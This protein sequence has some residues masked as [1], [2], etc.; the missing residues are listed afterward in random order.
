MWLAEAICPLSAGFS[1]PAR[2]SVSERDV[3]AT[4]GCAV[5]ERKALI[6]LRNV[7]VAFAAGDGRPMMLAALSPARRA[8]AGAPR[9]LSFV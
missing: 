2:R 1:E 6:R 5:A 9:R 3:A 4:A 8:S 7:L